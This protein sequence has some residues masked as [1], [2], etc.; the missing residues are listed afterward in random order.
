LLQSSF[1]AGQAGWQ[2]GPPRK[3]N[4]SMEWLLEKDGMWRAEK[5]E[6]ILTSV[7]N[8]RFALSLLRHKQL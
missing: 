3:A 8:P 7:S 5:V 4:M 6:M 1:A 2:P